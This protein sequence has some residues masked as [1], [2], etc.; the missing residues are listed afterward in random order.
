MPAYRRMSS[1]GRTVFA[2]A[3]CGRN[4]YQINGC[5]AKAD[6]TDGHFSIAG[7]IPQPAYVSVG[8][9]KERVRFILEPGT[10][11][12]DLNERT[13]SGLP[14]V[15]AV[16]AYNEVFYGFDRTRRAAR[17]ALTARK[18]E[19][20]DKREDTE[21]ELAKLDLPWSQILDAGKIPGELYG[22]NAIP[23]LIL[24]APDGTIFAAT[25]AAS[26]SAPSWK[27]S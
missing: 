13:V 14:K 10:A 6:G 2:L 21:A 3:A 4:G 26:R 22:V 25:C 17:E 23:H 11:K 16:K 9:G 8:H 18:D 5:Y 7:M 27:R 24:F 15:D 1:S 20:S 19:L 12:V